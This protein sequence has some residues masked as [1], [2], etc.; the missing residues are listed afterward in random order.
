MSPILALTAL[1]PVP[2]APPAIQDLR[3]ALEAFRELFLGVF[4]IPCFT[5]VLEAAS[6]PGAA[7]RE[8]RAMAD[9]PRLDPEELFVIRDGIESLEVF[10]RSC[11]LSVQPCLRDL[12]GISGFQHR[13]SGFGGAGMEKTVRSLFASAFP[14]NLDSLEVIQARLAAALRRLDRETAATAATA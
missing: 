11:R 4:D 2:P 1:D 5:Q 13:L 12:L 8:I 9:R 14:Q 7:L 6:F 3:S 10:L